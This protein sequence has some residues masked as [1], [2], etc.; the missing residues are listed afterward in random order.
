MNIFMY[1]KGFLKDDVSDDVI[2][3]IIEEILERMNFLEI[4][5]SNIYKSIIYIDGKD[6]I[7]EDYKPYGYKWFF[8]I[9]TGE[10]HTT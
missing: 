9:K 6:V 10:L 1:F 5:Y 4:N 2:T 3:I 8:D 7:F